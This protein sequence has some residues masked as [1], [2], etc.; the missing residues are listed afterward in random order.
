MKTNR[1]LRERR[2]GINAGI[3]TAWVSLSSLSSIDH[4]VF[5][6]GCLDQTSGAR[7]TSNSDKPSIW[8]WRTNTYRLDLYQWTRRNKES[9]KNVWRHM[10]FKNLNLNS[11]PSIYLINFNSKLKLDI[12]NESSQSVKLN[13][14]VECEIDIL[15]KL[16]QSH[17]YWSLVT[18]DLSPGLSLHK[19]STNHIKCRGQL[20]QLAAICPPCSVPTSVVRITQTLAQKRTEKRTPGER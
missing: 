15:L 20:E 9:Q 7:Y 10:S 8:I 17:N 13:Q 5:D 11:F 2:L 1:E 4:C 16:P 12:Q 19:L 3:T 14:S 18:R 6:V